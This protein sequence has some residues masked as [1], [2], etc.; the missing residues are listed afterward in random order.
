L[1][2]EVKILREKT[3]LAEQG[4]E[5]VKLIMQE[6]TKILD[7]AIIQTQNVERSYKKV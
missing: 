2:E 1:S 6:K 3:K 4:Y 5:N 7:D